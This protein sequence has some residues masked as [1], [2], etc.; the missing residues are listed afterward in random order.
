MA[1]RQI[2]RAVQDAIGREAE[3]ERAAQLTS[4]LNER[5][6]A[7]DR[8]GKLDHL[9]VEDVIAIISRDLGLDPVRMTLRSPLPGLISATEATQAAAPFATGGTSWT[10]HPPQRS[11]DG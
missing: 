6:E 3:G 2:A 11:P 5:L 1:R 7:L 8:E 4:A 9:P 10:A